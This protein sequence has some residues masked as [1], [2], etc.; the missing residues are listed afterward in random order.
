MVAARRHT[1]L[2]Q[3]RDSVTTGTAHSLSIRLVSVPRISQV[4]WAGCCVHHRFVTAKELFEFGCPLLQQACSW[5]PEETLPPF[6]G[7]RNGPSEEQW[8]P[9][10][11]GTPRDHA[12]TVRA[13]VRAPLPA[14][15]DKVGR[16]SD[17]VEGTQHSVWHTRDFWALSKS[18]RIPPLEN[19]RKGSLVRGNTEVGD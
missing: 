9:C 4:S 16:V 3:T 8:G 5:S 17:C 10:I 12:G 2:A 13:C 6:S 19:V 1:L 18:L 15:I 11:L 7:K 14:L